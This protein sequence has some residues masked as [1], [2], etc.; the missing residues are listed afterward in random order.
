MALALVGNPRI[1]ILDEAAKTG[2]GLSSFVS[3]GNR[4]DLFTQ[5]T[6]AFGVQA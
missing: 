2:V 1:A 5:A 3:A 4:A 6:A